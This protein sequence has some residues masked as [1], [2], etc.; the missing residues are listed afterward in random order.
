MSEQNIKRVPNNLQDLVIDA[1]HAA[2]NYEKQAQV[3]LTDEEY[4]EF[5]RE[6]IE[7]SIKGKI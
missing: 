2:C 3:T 5:I 4:F 7:K 6:H 1:D